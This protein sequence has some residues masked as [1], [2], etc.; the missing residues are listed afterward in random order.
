MQFFHQFKIPFAS[1]PIGFFSVTAASLAE[2]PL[3]PLAR[4]DCFGRFNRLTKPTGDPL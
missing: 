3:A 1:A 2:T 4:V